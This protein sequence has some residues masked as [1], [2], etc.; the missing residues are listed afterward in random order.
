[1]CKLAVSALDDPHRTQNGDDDI[2]QLFRSSVEIAFEIG[3]IG[4]EVAL[5]ARRQITSRHLRQ[6]LA[7]A[8]QGLHLLPQILRAGLL[9]LLAALLQGIQIS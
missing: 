6:G 3:E 9:R 4:S 5:Q 7:E 1:M 8:R 2:L